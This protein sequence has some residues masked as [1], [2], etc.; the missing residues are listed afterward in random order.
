[1]KIYFNSMF[2]GNSFSNIFITTSVTRLK[3]SQSVMCI[4]EN[5]LIWLVDSRLG[6]SEWSEWVSNTVF[7]SLR[8]IS[9]LAV[10]YLGTVP[11]KSD[12]T[13]FN[14]CWYVVRISSICLDSALNFPL[15]SAI[16]FCNVS[17]FRFNASISCVARRDWRFC[18]CSSIRTLVSVV[19][20]S[21][22][23]SFIQDFKE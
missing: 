5:L 23:Y 10:V 20:H 9:M 2:Y 15:L 16:S 6:Q 12:L 1:M 4:L 18:F 19:I 8:G 17:F 21:F 22:K 14:C 11:S 13:L 7:E 3:S